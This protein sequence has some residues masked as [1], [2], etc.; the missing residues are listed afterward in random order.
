MPSPQIA[1][2]KQEPRSGLSLAF[3][4][5]M[6]ALLL[7]ASS[8]LPA[9]A[10]DPV[11]D[12]EEI[13]NIR[14]EDGAAGPANP[15]DRDKVVN[16]Q[17]VADPGV[18]GLVQVLTQS[19]ANKAYRCG[20]TALSNNWVATSAHCITPDTTSVHIYAN[21]IDTS[22]RKNGLE[23][24]QIRGLPGWAP[25]QDSPSTD[26][27]LLHIP[28]LPPGVSSVPVVTGGQPTTPILTG[29]AFGRHEL[30][31]QNDSWTRTANAAAMAIE[32]PI[33]SRTLCTG[34]E[35]GMAV[36]CAGKPWQP[37]LTSPNQDFCTGDSGSPLGTFHN[38][39]Y[40]VVGIESR[41]SI[42]NANPA[43][44]DFA[45]SERCGFSPTLATSLRH[46]LGFLQSTIGQDLDT[47]M[48]P[49]AD[50]EESNTLSISPPRTGLDLRTP[51][52]QGDANQ[53]VRL[54]LQLARARYAR[55]N[56]LGHHVLLASNTSF[57][58][59]LS[60]AALQ[61]DK[62]L[63]YT[64]KDKVPNT[65]LS[66]LHIMRTKRVTLLG[67]T[68]TIGEG[69]AHHL[70]S[71]G[72][73]VDRIA[74]ADRLS[75][76]TAITTRLNAEGSKGNGVYL[77]RAF[78][79]GSSAFADSLAAGAAA[80]RRNWPVLLTSTEMLSTSSAKAIRRRPEVTIVGGPAAISNQVR[81]QVAGLVPQVNQAMGADRTKTAELLADP[82]SRDHSVIVLD[83]FDPSAWHGGFAA[84]GLAA[85]IDAP[86][87]LTNPA[88]NGADIAAKLDGM[89]P[90]PNA[91]FVCIADKS[92]C[93]V[94][95][96]LWLN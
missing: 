16:G 44:A 3:L 10:H 1:T 90:T 34:G 2:P 8:A 4:G 45:P 60:S 7:A 59:A 26:I 38:G 29:V 64:G 67:G 37:Q 68:A 40:A 15:A 36:V 86:I 66:Q 75:T 94:L 43:W 82:P 46:H 87:L 77:V 41:S 78:G 30:N 21:P 32:L 23:V 53:G 88:T 14:G 5:L 85:D 96:H 72:I 71:I 24:D 39:R 89:S 19:G 70:R 20:G 62:V 12:A 27:V 57:A 11:L 74:G 91:S 93:D 61:R 47:I 28:H 55:N 42:M 69:I 63:L 6:A 35:Q 81:L 13:L 84:S 58:D 56:A 48:L 33:Q 31:P 54:A 95:Y 49:V 83:G 18:Y 65:V 51:S 73:Q 76:A 92:L 22:R 50:E 80:A 79:Q 17:V 52:S 25:G 9:S